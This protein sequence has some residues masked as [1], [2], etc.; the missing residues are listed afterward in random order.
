MSD[1]EQIERQLR[2]YRWLF[3][4]VDLAMI[5]IDADGTYLDYNQA[6]YKLMGYDSKDKLEKYHPANVSPKKQ[7]N[8]QNSFDMANELIA[9]AMEKGKH[10]F[11]W[12][13]QRPDGYEFLSYVT[14]DLINYN[15]HQCIRAIIRDISETKKLELQINQRTLELADKNQQL[16][17]L[18]KTDHLTG[19]YNRIRMDEKLRLEHKL[20]Q[21]FHHSFGILLLDID[22]FKSINDTYGHPAGDQVLKEIAEILKQTCRSVDTICRWGGEEF[23]IVLPES[24]L[25]GIYQVAEKLR[26]QIELHPFSGVDPITASF[27]YDVFIEGDTIDSLFSRVDQALYQAKQKG[28]NQVEKAGKNKEN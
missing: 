27:G 15:N 9:I 24:D 5:I 7:P 2:D 25:D 16:E 19:L 4:T 23:L 12:M 1:H 10:S 18:A 17:L 21:R 22:N 14:L 20:F 13:H 11:E 28:K 26:L 8:G 6:Y 3:D